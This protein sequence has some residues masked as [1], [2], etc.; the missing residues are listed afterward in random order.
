MACQEIRNIA[1][2]RRGIRRG[3]ERRRGGRGAGV[4]LKAGNAVASVAL[5]VGTLSL[6][7]IILLLLWV[8]TTHTTHSE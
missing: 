5:V 7:R 4:G 1:Y 8:T 6:N 3:G 2:T